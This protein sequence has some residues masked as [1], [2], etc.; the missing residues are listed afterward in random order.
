MW[1]AVQSWTIQPLGPEPVSLKKGSLTALYP[2]T[3]LKKCCTH[4]R[5]RSQL[6]NELFN[7]FSK[8]IKNHLLILP[9]GVFTGDSSSCC[10]K[11][12]L[13]LIVCWQFSLAAVS[14][15][16]VGLIVLIGIVTRFTRNICKCHIFYM[17]V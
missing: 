3:R 14:L 4:H 10:R 8:N 11:M 12:V 13:D 17:V 1:R 16:G 6:T 7:Y 15:V 9:K 5:Q 2:F